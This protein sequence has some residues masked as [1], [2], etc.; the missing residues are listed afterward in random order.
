MRYYLSLGSNVGNREQTLREALLRIEQLIGSMDRCSSFFYSAP[1]GF[2]SPNE[3]C[4]LC[5]CVLSDKEPLEVLRLTQALER[6][7]GRQKKSSIINHQSSIRNYSDRSI[8]IDIIRVFDNDGNELF[9]N[10]PD[11]HIPH[12]LWEQRDFVRIPLAQ[13]MH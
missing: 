7:L 10:H 13:I 12:P 3:F 2:D 1:W 9:V 6:A 11:L 5:C 4:N 8:D